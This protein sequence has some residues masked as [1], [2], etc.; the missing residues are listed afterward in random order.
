ML[1]CSLISDLG[2]DLRSDDVLGSHA[3]KGSESEERC[4]IKD[5]V[6]DGGLNDGRSCRGR[7]GFGDGSG[8]DG[9]GSGSG[10][11][12]RHGSKEGGR[13]EGGKS[14]WRFAAG[15]GRRAKI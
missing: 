12:V 6:L 9:G 5:Q 2:E 10:E 14:G 3:S 15:P 4:S 13:E 11:F 8:L 7:S 1:P